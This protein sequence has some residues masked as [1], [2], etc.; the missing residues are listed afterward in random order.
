MKTRAAMTATSISSAMA[1]SCQRG[2]DGAGAFG[3]EDPYFRRW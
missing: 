2:P 1:Y 3:S